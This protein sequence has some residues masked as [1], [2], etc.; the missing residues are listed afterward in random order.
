MFGA[1]IILAILSFLIYYKAYS[2]LFQRLYLYL[3]IAT[4]LNEIVGIVSIEHHWLYP[5]QETVCEWV[6]LFLGWTYVLLFIFSY[7]IIFYLLYLVVS[8]IKGITLPQCG[9]ACTK[10]CGVTVEAVYIVLPLLISTAFAV[11][12]YK[13][14]RYGIAGPWCFVRSLS[15]DCKPIGKEFQLAFYGMYMALGVAGIIACLIF[16]VVYFKLSSSFKEVRYLLKR[17]LCVLVFKFVHILMIACSVTCRV[18]T[19][20]TQRHE[21]YV[22]WFLHALAVPLGVLVFPLGYFLCFH[23][24][25]KIAQIIYKKVAHKCCKHK[26]TFVQNEDR[27]MTLQSTAPKSN[28]VSQPSHTFFFA[29][30]PDDERSEKSHLISDTGYGSTSQSH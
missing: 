26:I 1:L 10:F 18:Y 6:G 21:Q 17:T 12:P 9:M 4:L 27:S 15:D 19:L 11:P 16:S 25:G 2:S 30:H 7:E 20:W 13:Q 28:R 29:S 3:I 24:L 14:Q 8:K 23:P 22:L 5:G